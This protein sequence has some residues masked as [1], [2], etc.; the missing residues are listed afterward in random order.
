MNRSTQ[1]FLKWERKINE[2]NT[3]RWELFKC[4]YP[5]RLDTCLADID[6]LTICFE[7]FENTCHKFNMVTVES[8]RKITSRKPTTLSEVFSSIANNKI[9]FRKYDTELVNWRINQQINNQPLSMFVYRKENEKNRGGRVIDVIHSSHLC[10]SIVS[11]FEFFIIFNWESQK[12][13][14]LDIFK[15]FPLFH[16][17]CCI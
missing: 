5:H 4:N 14:S 7:A 16:Y 15:Y 13:I 3:V 17:D 1:I 8:L 12:I 2:E 6:G 10:I 11:W 9:C